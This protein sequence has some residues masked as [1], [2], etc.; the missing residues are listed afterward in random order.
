MRQIDEA[1]LGKKSDPVAVAHEIIDS[2]R[3]AGFEADWIEAA[4]QVYGMGRQ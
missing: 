3:A 4:R 1:Y 2:M